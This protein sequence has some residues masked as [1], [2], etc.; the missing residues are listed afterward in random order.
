MIQ[1]NYSIIGLYILASIIAITF[2]SPFIWLIFTSLKPSKEIFSYPITIFPHHITFEHYRYVLFRMA[3]FQRYFSNSVV[4]TGISVG[5]IVILSCLGGYAF[6]RK[7]FRGQNLMM[8]FVL[9]ILTIP[10]AI[11]LVPIFIMEDKFSLTNSYLAL[12]LPYV[13]LNLPWGLFIMR[14]SFR[15]IPDE[16]EDSA[17]I[18]GANEWQLWFRVM[19]PLAKPG[20]A[21]TTIIT[22]I[23]VWQEF[24]FAVTL[25]SDSR[26]Q[27]LPVGIV[28]IRDELQALAYDNLSVAILISLIPIFILFLL[29]KNFFIKGITEGGLKG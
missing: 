9:L 7:R 5:L 17:R 10:Y 1:K 11:Y 13:A 23:F 2:L 25:Q 20:I 21:T 26:W 15:T 28:H 18:D 14:G 4:I 8:S 12:I 16:L 19:L 22:F 6:G 27:T 24:L 29:L 3:D